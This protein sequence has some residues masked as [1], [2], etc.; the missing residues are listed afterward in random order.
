VFHEKI[1]TDMISRSKYPQP[2]V[3]WAGGKSQILSQIMAA[4]P[5][6]FGRYYEPFIGGGALFLSLR[7][8]EATISDANFELINAYHVIKDDTDSLLT[9]LRILQKQRIS[10]TFY[11][12]YRGLDPESLT[13]P[14]RAARFILLNKTCFNGLYRVNRR[15][16]F[17]VPFG[18]YTRMPRLYDENNLVAIHNLLE[19]VDVMCSSYEIPLQRARRGDFVYLDPPYSPEPEATG[20]TSYT[21]ESF[22]ASDQKRLASKFKEL[23]R[24]GCLLILSNSNTSIV[25]ELYA[26]YRSTT[27]AVEADRMINCVGSERRGYT[28]L[29]VLNYTP[30]METLIPWVKQIN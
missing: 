17:N 8:D 16:V 26:Q 7:P 21:K 4:I 23:D 25:R 24:R 12:K 3:K 30:P 6:K 9:E 15:G 10:R 13:P 22:S 27:L 2:F 1:V 19:K 11:N 28:E 20:F 29:V 18:K 14:K 5:K